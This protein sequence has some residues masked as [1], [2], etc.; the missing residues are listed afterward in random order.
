MYKSLSSMSHERWSASSNID[1]YAVSRHRVEHAQHLSGSGA[2]KA[3]REAGVVAVTNPLH[4]V[5]DIDIIEARLGK[6]R[7]QPVLAFPT[8]ALMQVGSWQSV[9]SRHLH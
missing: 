3:L 8:K 6:G 2:L 7:A 9:K 5:S 1:H 4:L